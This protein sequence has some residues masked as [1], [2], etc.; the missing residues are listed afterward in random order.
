M[1]TMPSKP[2]KRLEARL[3]EDGSYTL[4][5]IS[6]LKNASQFKRIIQKEIAP[7]M[8]ERDSITGSN[9]ETRSFSLATNELRPFQLCLL[10]R[11]IIVTKA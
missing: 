2:M 7:C 1:L 6:P 4:T 10:K 9:W 5:F 8:S 3:E 11:L